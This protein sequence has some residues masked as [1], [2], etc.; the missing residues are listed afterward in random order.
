MVEWAGAGGLEDA[1]VLEVGGGIGAVA[2][3]L[4]RR[5]AERAENLEV[6]DAWEPYARELAREQGVEARLSFR[7]GDLLDE[8][9]LVDPADVVALQ[10]VVCCNPEGIRLAGIAASL[11]RNILVLSYPRDAVWTR[12]PVALQNAIQ[13]LLGRSFRAFV[14]D[15]DEILAAAEAAGLRLEHRRRG[16][17]WEIA[18]LTRHV[19]L[20]A[21][22]SRSWRARAAHASSSVAPYHR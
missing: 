6:V 7:V 11:A 2:V 19:P 20:Q 10:R 17:V 12:W 9:G 3:E 13:R 14:H 18:A 21:M 4:L 5:G 15:P 22:P 1:R 16:A 8:P